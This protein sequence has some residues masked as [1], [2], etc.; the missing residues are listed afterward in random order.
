MEDVFYVRCCR[1]RKGEP[2]SKQ[3]HGLTSKESETI[4]NE[5]SGQPDLKEALKAY[6][7]G[8]LF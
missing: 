7:S 6:L 3:G 2:H 8:L 4:P 1:N 5:M